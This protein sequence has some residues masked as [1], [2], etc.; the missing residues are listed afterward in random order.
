MNLISLI[1]AN[2]LRQT[3]TILLLT[4]MSVQTC[5]GAQVGD[6]KSFNFTGIMVESTP[7]ETN[8]N[9]PVTATFGNVGISKID[10]GRYVQELHYSLNCGSATGKNKFSMF[11]KATPTS[12]DIKSIATSVTGLGAQ[13]LKDGSPLELNTDIGI[14]D[15]MNPPTLTVRLVKDP[16]ETL[17]DQPFTAVGTIIFEYI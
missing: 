2:V 7:C 3:I 14:P 6:K 12:W 4:V 11:I 17:S 5:C 9:Q 8:G 15:P 13:I 1:S 16:N 10:T